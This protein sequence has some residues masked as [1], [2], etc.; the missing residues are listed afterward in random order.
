[1]AAAELHVGLLPNRPVDEIAALARLA[2]ELGFAGVWIADSQSVFRDAYAALTLC[3][4]ATEQIRLATAVTN[5]V[6]RHPAVIASAFATLQEQSGGRALVGIGIG[7]S[8]VRT[9]GLRPARLAELE[10]AVGTI[11]SL[12]GGE[13]ARYGGQEIRIAWPVAP[14]PIWFASSGPRSLELGGRIADGVLFQVGAEPALVSYALDHVLHGAS[15]TAERR[16]VRRFARLAC[17]V[18]DD[19][20]WAREQVKGYAAA[21]AGTVFTSV[22]EAAMPADLRADIARMKREYDYLEHT[23]SQARHKELLTDRVVD[24]V[25][26]T[27][28]PGEVAPR[29]R[30]LVELGVEGFVI[31]VTSSDPEASLRSLASVIP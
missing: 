10:Q 7:E 21:A 22:P 13:T 6:T 27:G 31:P 8:S 14:V 23:S 16:Q 19:P 30:E 15:G 1:M 9:L 11:R 12:L 17:S 3:A 24:A 20:E 25:A 28:T 29:L 18:A 26:I 2:E 5:P 4:A